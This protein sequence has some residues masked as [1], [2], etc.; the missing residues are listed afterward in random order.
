VKPSLVRWSLASAALALASCSSN[1]PPGTPAPTDAAAPP[2]AAAPAA[3][4]PGAQPASNALLA[5]DWDVRVTSA[6]GT[7]YDSQMRLRPRGDSYAGTML[8]LRQDERTYFVRSVVMTGQQVVIVLEAE[9]GEVRI[10]AVLRPGGQLDG[11]FSSRTITGR[12][13]AQRR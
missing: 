8:P 12:F 7:N 4:A 5:G 1:P 10:A 6:Q 3:G 9:D 13:A 2:A 11:S